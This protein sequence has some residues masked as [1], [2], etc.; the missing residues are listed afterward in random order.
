[1]KQPFGRRSEGAL[2]SL[3]DWLKITEQGGDRWQ[4]AGERQALQW[5]DYGLRRQISLS[6]NHG[7]ATF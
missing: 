7:F 2:P 3:A 5:E 6:L 4:G 1:M